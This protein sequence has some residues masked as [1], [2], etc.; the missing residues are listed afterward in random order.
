MPRSGIKG[1]IIIT[2]VLLIVFVLSIFLAQMSSDMPEGSILAFDLNTLVRLGIQWLNV[3]VMTAL[4]IFILY[5]PVKKFLANRRQR[6]SDEIEDARKERE[7]AAALKEQY[8]LI[9][10]DAAKERE[11]MFQKAAKKAAENGDK[12][13]FEAQREAE[14]IQS[15]NLAALE[16]EQAN[17]ANEMRNQI[18]E[19]S[20]MMAARFIELSMDKE[21]HDKYIEEAFANWGKV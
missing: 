13:L 7:E 2:L 4:I 1:F 8:E 16:Q 17:A 10:A 6:I 14:A 19:I 18:I 3:M 15:R 5:K 12:V 21:K 20:S 11:E 9:M